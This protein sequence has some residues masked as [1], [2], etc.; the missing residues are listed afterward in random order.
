MKIAVTTEGGDLDARV[1]SRF[2]RAK[3]FIFYD[4]ES[5]EFDVVNNHQILNLP[6]G[7]GIQAAQ[8]VIEHNATA[9]LTGNCGPN[10]YRTL[11][12]GRVQVYAG[13]EGIVKDAVARFRKGELSPLTDANVEGHW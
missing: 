13:V 7:A 2:G 8:Q 4:L 10:A 3:Y 5:D 1:D 9:L 12:A 11:E 6:Q